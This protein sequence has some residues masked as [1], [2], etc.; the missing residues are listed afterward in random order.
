[1]NQAESITQLSTWLNINQPISLAVNAETYAE[2]YKIGRELFEKTAL[3][4]Y[5]IGSSENPSLTCQARPQDGEVI[6]FFQFFF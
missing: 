2:S 1:M 3:V 6:I 5:T 4:V